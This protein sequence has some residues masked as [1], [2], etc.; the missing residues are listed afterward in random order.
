M[1]SQKIRFQL[2]IPS[3]KFMSYYQGNAQN[4][5]VTSIENKTIQFPAS[6]IRQFLSHEGIYG[7][8]EIQF[9]ENNKLIDI[10]RID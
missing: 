2:A 9:D 6:A 1:A 8:F 4:V 3:E 5:V 7:L 10:I